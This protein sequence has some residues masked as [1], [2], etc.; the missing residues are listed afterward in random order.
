[1]SVMRAAYVTAERDG[2]LPIGGCPVHSAA[3]PPNHMRYT[4]LLFDL[5]HTLFDFDTSEAVAFSSA[6]ATAGV[7][8]ENGYHDLFASINKALWVRVEAGELT[9][10]DVRVVRFE[11][12]FEQT[13]IDA[14]ARAIADDYITGLGAHGDLYPGARELLEELSSVATLALVSNGIGEVVSDKVTRLDLEGYFDAIVVSGEIGVAKPHTG[15]FDI[16]FDRLDHPDKAMTLMIGD[17]LGSDIRG[18]INY[19]ID[20]CWYA[21]SSAEASVTP[22]YRVEHLSEIPAV[23]RG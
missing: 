1:M 8:I 16:A 22:T 18:G 21:P 19:G 23:A 13:G 2:R 4:T 10:N 12:L 15:F 17:N 6:L 7:D 5:D 3:T 11:D 9:A 14:D 20:T